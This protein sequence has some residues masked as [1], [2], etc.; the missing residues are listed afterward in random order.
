[1]ILFINASVRK[2]SRTKILADRFLSKRNEPYNEIR[3]DEVD[4]P[5]VDEEFLNRR[6]RAIAKQDFGSPMFDLAR[7]FAQADSI[8]IAAPFWDLSFPATLKQYFEQIN[9]VGITF[10]YTSEG[11]PQGLCRAKDLTYI[12]TAGGNYFPE[13]YGFG[14]VKSLAQ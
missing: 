10:R 7:Q 4:F 9:V 12:T 8:V 2:G 14:Y 11:I 1:M 5:V 3:L 13:E 6:D